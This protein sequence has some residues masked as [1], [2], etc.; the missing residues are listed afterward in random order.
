M[1]A[2]RYRVLILEDDEQIAAVLED[3]LRDEGYEVRCVPNGWEGLA[4]LARWSPDVII[5]DLM[6]PV[7][8]GRSFRAAQ[9]RL[10]P[11]TAEVPVIVLSGARD[12]RAQAE[13]MAAAAAIAKP[14]ELDDVLS[15]VGRVCQQAR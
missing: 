2:D 5:L 10:P 14:F 8:D 15:T 4:E 6:M 3:T 11:A 9:R 1:P 7:L 12:A 13:A